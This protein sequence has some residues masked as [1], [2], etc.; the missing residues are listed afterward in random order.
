MKKAG[1]ELFELIHSLGKAEKRY[2]RMF[3]SSMQGGNKSY[4]KLYD[5]MEKQGAYNEVAIRS[6]CR[7]HDF[8]KH[9]SVTNSRLYNTILRTL[10]N[11]HRG[12]D[13]NLHNQLRKA[14][15]LLGKGLTAHALKLLKTAK[16][17]AYEQEQWELLMK[18]LIMERIPYA[19]TNLPKMLHLNEEMEVVLKKLNNINDYRKIHH[20]MIQMGHEVGPMRTSKE[21]LLIKQLMRHPLVRDSNQASC[22]E[23]KAYYYEI[24]SLYYRFKRDPAKGY[25]IS[26]E[27][28]DFIE[29]HLHRLRD[30]EKRYLFALNIS[31]IFMGYLLSVNRGLYGEMQKALQKI[32][33]YPIASP[34]VKATFWGNS[35]VNEL[36]AFMRIGDF[37]KIFPALKEI[38]E[39]KDLLNQVPAVN[40]INL[41][42]NIAYL[43]FG[44]GS[45]NE[46]LHWVRKIIDQP[47]NI[48]RQD[49]QAFAR[50]L[51]LLLHYELH[52]DEELLD[53]LKRSTL[54]FLSTRHRLFKVEEALMH[55]LHQVTGKTISGK[56]H[57]DAFRELKIS[58][59][60]LMKDQ[61]EKAA[62]EDFD[63]L[64]W[65]ESKIEN[66]TFAEV[67]RQKA[68]RTDSQGEE[69][70][71][72]Q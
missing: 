43:L 56:K 12:A 48:L 4:L 2:F 7:G 62:L 70:A 24:W 13:I 36:N 49:T 18:L 5:A 57:R 45:Y 50:I 11:Y 63:F 68:E 9:L 52:K 64:S 22:A 42:Y 6:A 51:N 61:M 16:A 14:E 47:I 69:K 1:A 29:T 40:K 53:S 38:E 55:C 31:V 60:K 34:A 72:H 27:Q 28:C 71:K 37:A 41:H 30:P 17:I 67:V 15:I 10:E 20:R 39:N 65:V 25:A 66:K 35:Y 26:K 46:A 59:L 54:H 33:S 44:A 58:L 23:S 32:R 19:A 3:S 21:L 8:L